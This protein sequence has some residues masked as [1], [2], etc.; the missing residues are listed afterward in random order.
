MSLSCLKSEQMCLP[1]PG[2]LIDLV[3]FIGN[4]FFHFGKNAYLYIEDL[5]I[6]AKVFIGLV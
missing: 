6:S 2:F 1:M 5:V 3:S 4:I